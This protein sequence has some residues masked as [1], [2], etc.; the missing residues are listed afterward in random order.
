MESETISS[1]CYVCRDKRRVARTNAIETRIDNNPRYDTLK[2]VILR[3]LSKNLGEDF[4]FQESLTAKDESLNSCTDV[5]QDSGRDPLSTDYLLKKV[6][7]DNNIIICKR[8]ETLLKNFDYYEKKAAAIAE[9]IG[10]FLKRLDIAGSQSSGSPGIPK[11]RKKLDEKQGILAAFRAMRKSYPAERKRGRKRKDTNVSTE[12]NENTDSDTE[13]DSNIEITSENTKNR[14]GNRCSTR[15]QRR[16]EEGLVMHWGD[17][18]GK[19]DTEGMDVDKNINAWESDKLLYNVCNS[20]TRKRSGRRP[21]SQTLIKSGDVECSGQPKTQI[22]LKYQC[23]FCLRNY[24]PSLSR[25]HNCTSYKNQMRCHFCNIFFTSHIRLEK[26]LEIIHLKQ[27]ELKCSIEGCSYMCISQPALILHHHFHQFSQQEDKS[28][29]E[30]GDNNSSDTSSEEVVDNGNLHLGR[31]KITVLSDRQGDV[32]PPETVDEVSFHIDEKNLLFGHPVSITVNNSKVKNIASCEDKF[33]LV[34]EQNAGVIERGDVSCPFCEKILHNIKKKLHFS[35]GSGLHIGKDEESKQILDRNMVSIDK[36]MLASKITKESKFEETESVKIT[37]ASTGE[38]LSLEKSPRIHIC[39]ICQKG[40]PSKAHL[41]EH[42]ITHSD[43]CSHTC[44]YCHKGFKRKN[45]LKRHFQNIHTGSPDHV[46]CECGKQFSSQD[47]MEKHQESCGN[48]SVYSCPNC[49]ILYKTQSSLES[50]MLLH[51]ED[52]VKIAANSWPF[53]CHLCEDRFSSKVSLNNHLTQT[54]STHNVKCNLC[55]KTFKTDHFLMGHILRKHKIGNKEFPCKVCNKVFMISKDLRRHMQSHNPERMYKCSV[56]EKKFKLY[57]TL[58]FHMKAHSK[59][60]PYDCVLCLIPCTTIVELKRHIHLVHK[61]EVDENFAKNWNRKCPVCGQLFLRRPTLMMHMKS[62]LDRGASRQVSIEVQTVN[63]ITCDVSDIT[64]QKNKDEYTNDCLR[65]EVD[66]AHSKLA[67][68]AHMS[69]EKF[70]EETLLVDNS[71]KD[72]ALV[73]LPN[74]KIG[75][76]LDSENAFSFPICQANTAGVVK[77]DISSLSDRKVYF[78]KNNKSQRTQVPVISTSGANTT[79][80][81]EETKYT[82]GQCTAVFMNVTDLKTHIVTCYQQAS[83]DE[84]IMVFEVDENSYK[85]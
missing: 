1:I 46:S 63:N 17:T 74:Q 6:G 81:Q 69:V 40:F 57:S 29:Q 2:D 72:G 54:H 80:T 66:G 33:S 7:N 73:G 43:K 71:H 28:I 44:S 84:Y 20:K 49:C 15:I 79:N 42:D 13:K 38:N 23:P 61:L 52:E 39:K 41:K 9:S 60:K 59:D 70:P 82:C 75:K 58:Q 5:F 16:R 34:K 55:N 14:I 4:E 47:I 64:A 31:E 51:R 25:I 83:S 8:C 56:C 36:V 18:A 68:K 30:S 12:K 37:G 67:Y 77:R 48:L 78:I 19:M 45:A 62:H 35:T 50:H 32:C 24:I 26:H 11:E 65:S 22:T 53:T 21:I 27:K 10:T 76:M 3:T 85:K